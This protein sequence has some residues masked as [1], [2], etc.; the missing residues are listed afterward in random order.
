MR[1]LVIRCFS[2][3]FGA[4]G[5]E[6]RLLSFILVVSVGQQAVSVESHVG[7]RAVQGIMGFVSSAGSRMRIN[8]G[9]L[10]A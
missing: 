3:W 2:C 5:E 1:I 9:T 8:V 6:L 10:T 4:F 7:A